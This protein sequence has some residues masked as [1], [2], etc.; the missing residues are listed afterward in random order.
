MMIISQM[1]KLIQ[2]TFNSRE[3]LLRQNTKMQNQHNSH[4]NKQNYIQLASNIKYIDYKDVE[5]L[6]HFTNPHA[7]LLS[8]K[9]TN[10]GAS[11]QRMIANSIK[12]ARFMGL[13]PYVSH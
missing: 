9:K 7:R 1:K 10:L 2:T 8:R 12:R 5:T 3:K 4:G 13:M 11:H 6:K